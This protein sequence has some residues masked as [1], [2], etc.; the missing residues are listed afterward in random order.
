MKA[1]LVAVSKMYVDPHSCRRWVVYVLGMFPRWRGC[2]GLWIL[3]RCTRSGRGGVFGGAGG[4][5]RL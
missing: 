5:E 2:S 1:S 4:G 3:S